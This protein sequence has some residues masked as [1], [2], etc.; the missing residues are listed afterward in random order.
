MN[1]DKFKFDITTLTS[2]ERAMVM[3]L[4]VLN[5]I[6]E[7]KLKAREAL[8]NGSVSRNNASGIYGIGTYLQYCDECRRFARWVNIA[9]PE[10][11]KVKY[12]RRYVAEYLQFLVDS[13]KSPSTIHKRASALA[14][15]YR[16]SSCDFDV[17]LPQR[18]YANFTRS[19]GYDDEQYGKDLAKYG[20]IVELCRATGV[21]ECELEHLYPECFRTDAAGQLYLHLDGREQET[22]GGLSRDVII[23]LA[24]QER[25]LEIISH[26]TPCELICPEAPSHLDI[27][28]IRAMY[29]MDYYA[30]IARPIAGILTERIK[31]KRPI[32]D[33]RRPGQV[34]TTAP[35]VYTRRSDGK[36]FDRRALLIVSESLGHHRVDVVVHSYLR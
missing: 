16:C 6:G 28:G 32:I 5:H 1:C 13:G 31:L 7:S 3:S 10:A 22:K 15:L 23:L 2:L 14:K 17:A 18:R 12:A 36:Q 4:A 9:H 35:A 20:E 29:A 26:F 30:A 24:N 19:R 11:V 33:K 8:N 25:V 21:R 34:R 27:H